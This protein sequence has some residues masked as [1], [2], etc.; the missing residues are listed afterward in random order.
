MFDEEIVTEQPLRESFQKTFLA[1]FA[2]LTSL[3]IRDSFTKQ[4]EFIAGTDAT[5][6]LWYTH[7]FLLIVL[8]ITAGMVWLFYV[9]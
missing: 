3:A 9:T 4:I 2:L 7:M 1:A 8:L 6:T 5:K